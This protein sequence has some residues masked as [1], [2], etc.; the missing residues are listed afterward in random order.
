MYIKILS[1]FFVNVTCMKFSNYQLQEICC[2]TPTVK[3]KVIGDKLNYFL[4][5]ILL[6]EVWNKGPSHE[7]VRI[8]FYVKRF[9]T[10]THFQKL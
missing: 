10:S 5:F 7:I 2:L 8:K 6:T 4:L 1:S 9:T 3:R